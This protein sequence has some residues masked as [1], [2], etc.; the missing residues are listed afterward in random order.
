MNVTCPK[1]SNEN[2]FHNGLNYE[3]PDCDFEWSD[4]LDLGDYYDDGD[5]DFIDELYK[6]LK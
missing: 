4:G 1:C 5:D 3:C 6:T 2:A